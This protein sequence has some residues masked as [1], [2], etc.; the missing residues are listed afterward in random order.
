[1][2]M[3]EHTTGPH[4]EETGTPLV[5]APQEARRRL[6]TL[7]DGGAS[8]T[9]QRRG[10]PRLQP[11]PQARSRRPP[12]VAW[13]HCMGVAA[14]QTTERQGLQVVASQAVPMYQILHNDNQSETTQSDDEDRFALATA[15]S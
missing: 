10:Q 4:G 1:M 13:A 3:G 6:A 9:V 2:Q 11:D 12:R 7:F 15:A 8:A 5:V 14:V